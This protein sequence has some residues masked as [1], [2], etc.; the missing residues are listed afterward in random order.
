MLKGRRRLPDLTPRDVHVAGF[1]GV[2]LENDAL[3]VV[4]VPELGGKIASLVSRAT[5]REWLWRNPHLPYRRAAR[6]DSYVA[7]HDTGGIDECFPTVAPSM[8][9][10]DHGELYAQPW[11]VEA[12]GD[13][14]IV[15]GA[16]GVRASYR[17]SR[18]LQLAPA[19]ARLELEYQVEN[20]SGVELP[21]VWC[22]H[23]LFAIEP[24][25]AIELPDATPLR[26]PDPRRAD[27][28]PSA[29]KR[30]A[31][32]LPRGEVA[33]RT[34]DARESLRLRF[35]IAEIPFVGLW[36]NYAGWSGAGSAPY[37]N[38][39]LEPSIGD[40]DSLEEARARGTAGLLAPGARRG[41]RVAL[42]LAG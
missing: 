5:G 39:A 15:L 16:R 27:F 28:T 40:S 42:E 6:G 21:F 14:Q 8:G 41:W 38:L 32:P 23:P 3:E 1:A 22:L 34:A 17:F 7:L 25:M 20:L 19:A 24:G 13:E 36:L 10:P 12:L 11:T 2:K 33:L 35:D 18:K 26:V 37:F 31:G 4:V 30:F 29:T 9:F